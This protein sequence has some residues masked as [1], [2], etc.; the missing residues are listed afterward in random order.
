MTAL[1]YWLFLGRVLEVFG[2]FVIVVLRSSPFIN[3][4]SFG[5]LA[6]HD[7]FNTWLLIVLFCCLLSL[8]WFAGVNF[9]KKR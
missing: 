2:N 8:D 7:I 6:S 3:S 9:R 4:S 1:E 5:V